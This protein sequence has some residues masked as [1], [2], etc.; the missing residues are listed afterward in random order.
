MC[1]SNGARY[2][3]SFMEAL[4]KYT[5]LYLLHHKSR[6]TAAFHRFK[7]FLEK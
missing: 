6:A 1:A 2:Y 3:I 5:W 4:S 7:A